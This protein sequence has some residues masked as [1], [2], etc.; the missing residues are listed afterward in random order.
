MP[1]RTQHLLRRA[2]ASPPLARAA[3]KPIAVSSATCGCSLPGAGRRVP[4]TAMCRRRCMP[5]TQVLRSS[6]HANTPQNGSRTEG[7]QIQR[8][9]PLRRER[10]MWPTV[11][12][13]E[14]Y[15]WTMPIPDPVPGHL[16]R[17]AVAIHATIH[18]PHTP[19]HRILSTSAATTAAGRCHHRISLRS[20]RP[21]VLELF[22]MVHWNSLDGLGAGHGV[23]N[24]HLRVGCNEGFWQDGARN[25]ISRSHHGLL[26]E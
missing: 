20:L 5:T 21:G 19:L 25:T 17:R 6:R 12:C 23:A 10:T 4:P 2:E 26:R 1:T 7:T 11:N 3:S 22:L 13:H 18:P 16:P 8:C 15:L 9:S 14:I 24:L